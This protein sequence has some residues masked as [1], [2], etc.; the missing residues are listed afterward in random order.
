MQ[1]IGFTDLPHLQVLDHHCD[2][3]LSSWNLPLLTDIRGWGHHVTPLF[4]FRNQLTTVEVL[5]ESQHVDAT[6]LALAVYSMVNLKHLSVTITDCQENYSDLEGLEPVLKNGH[7]VPIDTLEITVMEY[8]TYSAVGPLYDALS[9]LFASMFNLTL[10][11]LSDYDANRAGHFYFTTKRKMFPYGSAINIKVLG[12]SNE[13]E[14]WRTFPLL[15]SLV[16]DCSIAHT[17][18]I[19]AQLTA[20]LSQWNSSN[21]WGYFAA[22]R[23]LRLTRCDDLAE[24]ELKALVANLMIGAE[25]GM[26]LQSLEITDCRG[27]SEECLLELCDAVGPKLTW[28]GRS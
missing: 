20:F 4:T 16:T 27:I 21:E 7:S 5:L 9:F 28:N 6:A 25:P 11:D 26:G 8:S 18:R 23:H 24:W 10:E 17:I 19:E 12:V 22:L 14:Q 3:Q 13:N 1:E 2:V 15:T